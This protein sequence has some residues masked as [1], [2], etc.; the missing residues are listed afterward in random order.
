[1]TN[2][3]FADTE[4]PLTRNAVRIV[5]RGPRI[6]PRDAYAADHVIVDRRNVYLRRIET[7]VIPRISVHG[8][9]P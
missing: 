6:S 1:M 5:A 9:R 3:E 2:L 4:T 7:R 8:A